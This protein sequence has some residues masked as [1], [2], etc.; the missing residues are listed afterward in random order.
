MLPDIAGTL[1]LSQDEASWIPTTYLSAL[2]FGVPLSVWMAG[3]VGHLGYIV[4]SA[5]VAS[6]TSLQKKLASS[7]RML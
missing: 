1:G 2:L 3:H 7:S 5:V 6:K 4:G